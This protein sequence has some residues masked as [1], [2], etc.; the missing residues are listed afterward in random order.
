MTAQKL[1]EAQELSNDIKSLEKLISDTSATF[2]IGGYRYETDPLYQVCS[3]DDSKTHNM[4]TEALTQRL[5]A[6]KSKFENL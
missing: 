5:D 6:L 3:F 1:T 2:Y 4:I